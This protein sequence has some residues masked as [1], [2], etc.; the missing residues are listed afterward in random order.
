MNKKIIGIIVAV[1]LIVI[2][3]VTVVL[4]NRDEPTYNDNGTTSPTTEENVAGGNEN[5]VNTGNNENNSNTNSDVSQGAENTEENPSQ[6]ENTDANVNN[7]GEPV[8]SE[9]VQ[10]LYAKYG[11]KAGYLAE[12]KKINAYVCDHCKKHDCPGLT[13]GKDALG[14]PTWPTID[15]R[16][17]P[18]I[19]SGDTKCPVCGAI[20]V[21]DKDSRWIKYPDLY[22]DGR[23]DEWLG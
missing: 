18:A 20:L 13:Y 4:V 6:Q 23:C 11:G 8:D 5:D 10:E 2:A 17:C 16:K 12:Q 7:N 14:N 19:I 3:V 1:L 15:D 22:C 9:A 21:S